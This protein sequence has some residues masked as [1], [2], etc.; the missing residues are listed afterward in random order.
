ML[1]K[2]STVENIGVFSIVD[3][4]PMVPRVKNRLPLD[5][6]SGSRQ[7]EKIKTLPGQENKLQLKQITANQ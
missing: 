6:L 2:F 4:Y 7:C 3:F 1:A 5:R